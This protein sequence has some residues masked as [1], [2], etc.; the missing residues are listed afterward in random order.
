MSVGKTK[1][2]VQRPERMVNVAQLG[3]QQN[4]TGSWYEECAIEQSLNDSSAAAT[5]IGVL[6]RMN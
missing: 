6:D 4:M 3:L 2:T 1:M 5:L